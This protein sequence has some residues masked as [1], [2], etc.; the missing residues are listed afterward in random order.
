M[1]TTAVGFTTSRTKLCDIFKI[2]RNVRY[3]LE[4]SLP[5]GDRTRNLQLKV[6][7][8]P[9]CHPPHP[10]N[11]EFAVRMRMLPTFRRRPSPIP[12]FAFSSLDQTRQTAGGEGRTDG[13]GRAGR[14]GLARSFVRSFRVLESRAILRPL[15]TEAPL[16]PPRR[17]TPGTRT[18][19]IGG[20]LVCKRRTLSGPM[21]HKSIEHM[22]AA[23]AAAVAAAA[24]GSLSP[25]AAPL[26]APPPR[27]LTQNSILESEACTLQ[28]HTPQ[29]I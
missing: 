13:G 21:S 1:E 27:Q 11:Q 4:S 26:S 8:M 28:C 6:G 16:L 24:A 3:I 10:R 25:S 19:T 9:G 17:R 14:R 7:K 20:G 5:S 15:T 29:T 2:P 22:S 12:L 23:V 18:R